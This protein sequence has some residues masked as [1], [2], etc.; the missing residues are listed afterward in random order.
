MDDGN[1]T[2]E[3]K[4]GGIECELCPEAVVCRDSFISWVFFV[5]GLVATIAIRVG[6]VLVY[7]SPLYTKI[8]WYVGVI[9]F[10]LFFLYQYQVSR[11]RIAAIESLHLPDKVHRK[12]PLNEE[13]YIVISAVICGLRSRKERINYLVIFLLS[14]VSLL[15]AIYFDLIMG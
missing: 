4:Y 14:A 10:F 12:Q 1:R 11:E 7:I 13:D 9:G 8:A 2:M 5:I 6:I 3:Q 15:L